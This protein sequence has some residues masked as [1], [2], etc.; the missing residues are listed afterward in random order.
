MAMR[1]TTGFVE[2]LLRIVGL[3]W[4]VPDFSTVSHRQNNL[5][6]TI[7]FRGLQGALHRRS[8]APG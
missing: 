6:V 1:Q 7:P 4:E 8:K 3:D 2:S 5:A